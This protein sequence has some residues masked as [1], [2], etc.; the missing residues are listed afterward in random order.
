LATCLFEFEKLMQQFMH[1]TVVFGRSD[2]AIFYPIG[3]LGGW[4]G[5]T[6][7]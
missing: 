6:P 5:K 2:K 4:V 1:F 7:F 3:E